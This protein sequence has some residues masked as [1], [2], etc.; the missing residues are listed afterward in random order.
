VFEERSHQRR[1]KIGD[2]EFRGLFSCSLGGEAEQQFE[3]VAVGG[4]R[5]R[6]GVALTEQPFGEERLQCRSERANDAPR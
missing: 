2:V 4:D 3:R 6:A 5:V 1:V